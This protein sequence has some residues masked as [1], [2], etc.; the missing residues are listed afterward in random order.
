MIDIL[1][2]RRSIR[3]FKQLPVDDNK[4]KILEE[5][6][7]RSPSSRNLKPWK[8]IFVTDKKLL[9][10]LAEAKPA[11]GSFLAGAPLAVV[12]LGDAEVSN[13]WVEDCSIAATIL[14]LTAE[15]LDLGSCWVQ[16]RGR[17]HSEELSASAYIRKELFIHAEME[18]VSV[19]A[20]GYPNEVKELIP[21]HKLDWDKTALLV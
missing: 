20:I 11:G 21:N 10:K 18:V 12:V 14:Q 7:L 17:K 16:I 13:C 6:I 1:R 5:A 2:N 15:T 8:F 9:K 4:L 3:K 19:I